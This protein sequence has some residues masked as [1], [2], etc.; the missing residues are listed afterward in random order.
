MSKT[1]PT[2][3]FTPA[4]PGRRRHPRTA[5]PL[6]IQIGSQRTRTRD[7][8]VGGMGVDGLSEQPAAGTRLPVR[9]SLPFEGFRVSFAARARVIHH[10]ARS[11][12]TGLAYSGLS[13]RQRAMLRHFA[14][15]LAGHGGSVEET[16]PHPPAP[17]ASGKG[18]RPRRSPPWPA[19]RR[20]A[21][22]LAV[23]TLVMLLAGLAVYS[24]LFRLEVE[25]AVVSTA[26]EPLQ[27]P[28]RGV[29]S[30]TLVAEGSLV[31]PGQPLLRVVNAELQQELG[32][33]RAQ[34][35]E[36]RLTHRQQQ[37]TLAADERDLG[38]Y[39][40]LAG[41]SMAAAGHRVQALQA[42]LEATGNDLARLHKLEAQAMVSRA[43]VDRAQAEHA[44]ARGE[45]DA[46]RAALASARAV[47]GA[48]QRGSYFS[49]RRV[50]LSLAT[51]QAEAETAAQ[52]L[53][54]EEAGFAALQQRAEQLVV[55]APYAATV[56]KLAKSAG[57]AFQPVEPLVYLARQEVPVIDAFLT[58]AELTRIRPGNRARVYLPALDT[59]VE[60]VVSR[61]D[62]TAQFVVDSRVRMNWENSSDRNGH[63]VLELPDL[64]PATRSSLAVGTPAIV[65]FE[66]YSLPG[67]AQSVGAWFGGSA[68][69]SA[70]AAPARKGVS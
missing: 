39:R 56:L 61:V 54:L 59:V 6:K 55:S 1:S 58:Q 24:R 19:L 36:V 20:G 4:E 37:A 26:V 48:A 32:R 27:L 45:L 10:D 49:D 42:K 28:H 35:E 52:R 69:R 65:S 22:Y 2:T 67:L 50:E 8:S 21:L 18:V 63:A 9:I 70:G 68:T 60:G 38:V 5:L 43:Q 53:K 3:G 31:Q 15:H 12:I 40:Q 17:D 34:L 7:W 13:E 14:D 66:R 51:R 64:D 44:L 41:N 16:L 30:A 46:A 11:G 33:A 23:S 29:V 47:A 62:R 25:S 57:N